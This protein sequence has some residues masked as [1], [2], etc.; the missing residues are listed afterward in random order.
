LFDIYREE[1]LCGLARKV[2]LAAVL[3]L[4]FR[5]LNNSGFNITS[6]S[7]L[8][9]NPLVLQVPHLGRKGV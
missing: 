7:E 6:P 4:S 5:N 3:S 1:R 2:G 9:G 8:H